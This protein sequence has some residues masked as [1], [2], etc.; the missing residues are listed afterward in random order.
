MYTA[1]VKYWVRSK[2]LLKKELNT[3]CFSAV[4]RPHSPYSEFDIKK[5]KSIVYKCVPP[6]KE[7][8]FYLDKQIQ[9][10]YIE[11]VTKLFAKFKYNLQYR[12]LKDKKFLFRLTLNQK[13]I[14][15]PAKILLILTLFRY[16]Q[17]FPEILMDFY[18]N[19]KN[20]LSD[21]FIQ[22]QVSH[23]NTLKDKKYYDNRYGH[24]IISQYG[25]N[26]PDSISLEDF[27]LKFKFKITGVQECFKSR[28]DFTV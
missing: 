2:D 19:K 4:V 27:S 11:F 7:S 10:F 22:F 8:G 14:N 16:I 24:S 13:L 20:N 12:F 18:K 17:E 28:K 26:L 25:C 3:N 1:N 5:T 9:D 6:A 15:N 23:N 21:N